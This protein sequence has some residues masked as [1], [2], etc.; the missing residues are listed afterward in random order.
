MVEW[1]ERWWRWGYRVPAS[2]NPLLV[3]VEPDCAN[4]QRGHVWNLPISFASPFSRT[5]DI[6]SSRAIVVNLSGVL[7]DYPCPD[8]SFHPAKGQTLYQFLI[9]GAA[10]IVNA[11]FDLTLTVDGRAVPNAMDY[12]FTS[13]RLFDITGNPTLQPVLD[14]CITGKPQPAISDGYFVMLRPLPVGTHT[15][16]TS[17][18]DPNGP[19]ADTITVHSRHGDSDHDGDDGE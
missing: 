6:P 7:N 11:V 10:P 18:A 2:E 14:G 5:C 4:G 3:D 12:R 1:S 9:Q 17:G 8:T 19:F 16:I 15:I 13:P